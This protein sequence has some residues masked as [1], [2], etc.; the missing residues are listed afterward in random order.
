MHYA[1]PGDFLQDDLYYRSLFELVIDQHSVLN[2]RRGE[3]LVPSTVIR[4]KAVYLLT[5]LNIASGGGPGSPVWDPVL[6]VLPSGL[7]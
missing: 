6:E 1:F 7:A 4:L 2:R 5:H 3:V